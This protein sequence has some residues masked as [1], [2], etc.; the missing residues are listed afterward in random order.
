VGRGK[1]KLVL[2]LRNRS[3]PVSQIWQ[4]YLKFENQKHGAKNHTKWSQ[5]SKSEIAV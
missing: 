3:N 1:K 2:D 5:F 4:E